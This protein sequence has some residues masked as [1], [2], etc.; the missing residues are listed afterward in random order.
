[1]DRCTVSNTP[2]AEKLRGHR[3]QY[4]F[5]FVGAG[6]IAPLSFFPGSNL[7]SLD[8]DQDFVVFM[9]VHFC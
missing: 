1:M 6:A 8:F 3:I 5:A 4:P 9:L 2:A 7:L